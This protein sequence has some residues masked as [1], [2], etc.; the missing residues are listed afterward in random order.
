MISDKIDKL[1]LKLPDIPEPIGSYLPSICIRDMIFIS[2]QLPLIDGKLLYKGKLGRDI[3]IEQGYES[4][5]ICALNALSIVK[6]ELG[7]LDKIKQIIKIS[8][9]VN[10]T[11]DFT[12]HPQ[13]ING[14]SDLFA[15]IFDN[16]GKHSRIAIGTN[17]LPLDSPVEIDVLFQ[18]L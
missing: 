15:T 13:V 8:G 6:K 9:F 10:C 7:D 17:S 3:S 11:E 5:R 16:A 14:A 12:N 2:G 1:G 4:A 18:S